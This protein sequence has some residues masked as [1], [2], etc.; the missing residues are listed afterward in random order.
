[1]SQTLPIVISISRQLGSGAAFIGQQLATRLGILYLDREILQRAAVQLQV[2]EEDLQPHDETAASFWQSMI[3]SFSYG[4]PDLMFTP[5]ALNRPIDHELFEVE[6]RII[7]QVAQA[8]SAV[9]VGRGGVHVLREHPRHLSIYLYANQAF[10]M[11]RVKE[12]YHL[13]DKEACS[14]MEASDHARARYHR[15]VACKDWKDAK[16]YQLCLD[17]SML[18]LAASV[19]VILCCV[20]ERFG[21]GEVRS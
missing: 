1:M 20:A 16:Q 15:L 4:S 8:Q 2:S 13:T 19:K 21:V 7:T 3:Q 12:I 18:G 6:S 10:R 14:A 5:P 17:T 11:Q 9:V